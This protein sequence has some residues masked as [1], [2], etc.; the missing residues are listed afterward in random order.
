MNRF[1]RWLCVLS[2]VTTASCI[3]AQTF[4]LETKSDSL[5]VLLLETRDA[6]GK[7][8]RIAR[9]EVPYPIYRFC[10][11]DVNGDGI[12][13][14]LVGVIKSTRFFPEK[15]HRLFVFKNLRG[16]IRPLWMG[17][18]LGGELVDFKV[19]DGRLRSLEQSADGKRFAVG[20]YAWSR[21]GPAFEKYLTTNSSKHESMEIFL[22]NNH[23]NGRRPAGRNAGS[24]QR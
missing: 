17:S 14:A 18:R 9:W 24:L 5:H 13:E 1:T 6:K 19:A 7:V 12:E 22:G 3:R 23:P 20:I 4:R 16:N 11:G 2:L 8:T 15:G 21:F 10:T